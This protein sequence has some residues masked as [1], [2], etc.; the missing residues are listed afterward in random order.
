MRSIRG[1]SKGWCNLRKK[2]CKS[3]IPSCYSS[4]NEKLSSVGYK[5]YHEYLNSEDW[6]RLRERKLRRYPN[7][8]ICSNRATQVH[9]LKYDWPTLLGLEQHR[10]VQL[11]RDCHQS[12]EIDGDKKRTLRQANAELFRLAM[13]HERGRRWAVWVEIQEGNAKNRRKKNR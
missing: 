4:R 1:S 7:C 2:K 13:Q 9:H 8:L 11:C 10:L 3:G 12:I 5:S 6:K